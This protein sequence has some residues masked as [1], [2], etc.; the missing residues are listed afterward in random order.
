MNTNFFNI[1]QIIL[2]IVTSIVTKFR[3]E[4]IRYIPAP[5]LGQIFL[6]FPDASLRKYSIYLAN[7]I[8]IKTIHLVS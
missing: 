1:T 8:H 2:K 7:V 5:K 6:K 4:K 3:A